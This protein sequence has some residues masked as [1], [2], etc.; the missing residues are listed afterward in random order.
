[1]RYRSQSVAYWYFAVAMVLFGL[2]LLVVFG[3]IMTATA[4]L[5]G[6]SRKK[7]YLENFSDHIEVCF[8]PYLTDWCVC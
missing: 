4:W 5:F 2:V 3:L 6:R 8:N 1:M 7:I